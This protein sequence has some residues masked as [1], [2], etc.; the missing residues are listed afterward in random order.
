MTPLLITGT[1]T[2]YGGNI[3]P[4]SGQSHELRISA[5]PAIFGISVDSIEFSP[6]I[7]PEPAIGSLLF[8]GGLLFS[9]LRRKQI[10]R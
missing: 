1:Y 7:V 9:T 10:S 3:T 8:A 4:F 5:L 6:Q 2:L